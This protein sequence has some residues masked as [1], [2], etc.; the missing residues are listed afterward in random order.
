MSTRGYIYVA[1]KKNDL[2]TTL[3]FDKKLVNGTKLLDEDKWNGN[4]HGELTDNIWEPT[5]IWANH[6]GIY[7]QCDM[8]P[9]GC[10]KALVAH[11]NDY[12]KAMNLVAGGMAESIYRDRIVYCKSRRQ[13]HA[14][15]PEQQHPQ[16][17][18]PGNHPFQEM[19][20]ERLESFQYLFYGGRWYIRDYYTY[21]YDLQELLEVAER[22]GIDIDNAFGDAAEQTPEYLEFKAIRDDHYH[23]VSPELQK[24]IDKAHLYAQWKWNI[25]QPTPENIRHLDVEKAR[26]VLKKYDK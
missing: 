20:P 21:F 6:L 15:H 7:V 23:N 2:G 3:E 18:D 19:L 24:E 5:K 10:G 16:T 13:W 1:V 17:P 22:E 12:K 9:T 25:M 8:Y 26:E 4:E 11:Y 14:D